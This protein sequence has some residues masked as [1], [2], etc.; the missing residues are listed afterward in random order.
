MSTGIA[1]LNPADLSE[2]YLNLQTDPITASDVQ[3]EMSQMS[4]LFPEPRRQTIFDLA[5]D[6]SA[7]LAA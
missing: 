4:M 6:L 1:S 2:Q 7:G 5:S 3:T